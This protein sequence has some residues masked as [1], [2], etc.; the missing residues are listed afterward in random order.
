MSSSMGFSML[1]ENREILDHARHQLMQYTIHLTSSLVTSGVRFSFKAP[2]P[3][4]KTKQKK[5]TLIKMTQ[6]NITYESSA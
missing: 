6:Q 4:K 3:T 2:L 1:V 5:K